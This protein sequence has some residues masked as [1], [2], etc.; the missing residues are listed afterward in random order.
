[1]VFWR[2]YVAISASTWYA[3]PT[4]NGLKLSL[5]GTWY[6]YVSLPCFQFLLVRWY[7]RIFIWAR[8][9]WQVSRIELSLVP[10]HPD[11]VGGLGFL[12]NVVYAFTPLAVAHGAM[13][14]GTIAN[15]ILYTG[16]ALTDFKVEIVVLV[17]FMACVILG[18]FFVF[19][20]QLAAAKRTGLRE[21]GTL[22]RALKAGRFAPI[23]EDLRLY[24]R[25]ATLDASAPLS[26]LERQ[27]PLWAEASRLLSDWGMNQMAE[28]LAARAEPK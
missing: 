5:T 25:I 7:Y 19:S 20:P 23:A 14:S 17:L 8:F 12:S 24:R 21:Y 9:L 11:R 2:Q 13:V 16:A 1:M 18:P 10:T 27:S 3:S 26:P 6:A 28:R 15:R 22:E 4:A